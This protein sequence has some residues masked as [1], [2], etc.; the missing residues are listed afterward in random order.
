MNSE[1]VSFKSFAIKLVSD[2]AVLT[3]GGDV[4]VLVTGS[5][6]NTTTGGS[7]LPASISA[8]LGVHSQSLADVKHSSHANWVKTKHRAHGTHSHSQRHRAWPREGIM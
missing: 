1:Q 2:S 3:S 7:S 8:I 5:D 4:W 6:H